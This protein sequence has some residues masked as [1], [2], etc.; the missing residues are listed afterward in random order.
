MLRSRSDL[1]QCVLSLDVDRLQM[2]QA[3]IVMITGI[4]EKPV[5]Q[6]LLE[7]LVG[8]QPLIFQPAGI[9]LFKDAVSFP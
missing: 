3:G 9:M 8:V 4:F 5:P 7:L 1:V 2:R 6:D